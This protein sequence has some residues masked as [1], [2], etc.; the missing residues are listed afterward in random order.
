MKA[1]YMVTKYLRINELWRDSKLSGHSCESY[2]FVAFQEEAVY[3][4]SHL[5]DDVFLMDGNV[6]V[7]ID[8]FDDLH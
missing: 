2:G 1:L 4:N 8:Q 6:L 3:H 5:L 7:F